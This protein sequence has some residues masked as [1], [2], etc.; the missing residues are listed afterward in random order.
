MP[1]GHIVDQLGENDRLADPSTPEKP[2]LAAAGKRADQIEDL[3]AGLQHFVCGNLVFVGRGWTV[4]GHPGRFAAER[5]LA[6]DWLAD[7]VEEPAEHFLAH[8]NLDR[9]AAINYPR[10]APQ[11]V[12]RIHRY[13]AHRV[14]A[15]V[16]LYFED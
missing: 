3:Q 6:V 5:T 12:G 10:T 16:L 2:Q 7:D 13:T 11:A 1:R 15:Q 8:W 9:T 4:Q 14:L